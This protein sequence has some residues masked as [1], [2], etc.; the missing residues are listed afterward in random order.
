[1]PY[2]PGRTQ[3]SLAITINA[4]KHPAHPWLAH[5]QWQ[6]CVFLLYPQLGGRGALDQPSL[7][8]PWGQQAISVWSSEQAGLALWC[9]QSSSAPSTGEPALGCQRA[10]LGGC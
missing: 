4:P 2:R 8:A 6:V 3:T 10:G 5:Q 7:E 9:L 1:M